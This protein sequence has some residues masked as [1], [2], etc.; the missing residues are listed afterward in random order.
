[1]PA[2]VRDRPR[3]RNGAH[4]RALALAVAIAVGALSGCGGDDD[5]SAGSPPTKSTT[6][7]QGTTSGQTETTTGG[8]DR[9]RRR[10]PLG[11]PGVP[12]RA[13]LTSSDPADACGRFVTKRYLRVAY[14]GR[15]GCIQAQAPGSAARS[16]RSFKIVKE[17]TQDAIAVATAVPNGGPY[18]G[19]KLTIRL[20][21]GSVSYQVDVLRSNVPVGP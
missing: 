5:D 15:Q 6:A 19:S 17:D 11:D 12:V 13:V 7:A 10:G 14:G 16:L 4:A 18:D 1:V 8:A 9:R 3:R 2:D 21:G 20:I